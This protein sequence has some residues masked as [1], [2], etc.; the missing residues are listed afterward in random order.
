MKKL[1]NILKITKGWWENLECF[2]QLS[3]QVKRFSLGSSVKNKDIGG[4]QVG[5]G[6]KKII[7]VGCMHGNEIGTAKLMYKL[8]NFLSEQKSYSVFTFYIVPKLNPDGLE[9]ALKNPDYS[10]GGRVGRFNANHVD[11]NRNFPTSD[12]QRESVWSY[13]RDYSQKEEVFGGESAGSEPEVKLLC[14]FIKN[15]EIKALFSFHNAGRDVMGNNNELSQ[16]L[17]KI[18]S[19]TTGFRLVLEGEW[20]KMTQTGTAKKW[21]DENNLAYVEVEGSNRWGSDWGKQ[22]EAIISAI[23]FLKNK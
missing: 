5:Q 14:N 6:E 10:H 15:Q 11:L 17:I 12:W 21:C 16:E 8:I 1:R 2:D 9:T 18:Y 3:G 20:Q 13:G 23:E 22:K 4:Y 7:F 19:K